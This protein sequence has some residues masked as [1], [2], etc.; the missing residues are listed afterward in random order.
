MSVCNVVTAATAQIHNDIARFA[1]TGK[2]DGG[3][4]MRL[5]IDCVGHRTTADMFGIIDLDIQPSGLAVQDDLGAAPVLWEAGS[6]GDFTVD[7]PHTQDV[8]PYRALPGP[9]RS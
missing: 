7:D 4:F 8:I 2:G 9:R 5:A 6:N 1:D 3:G